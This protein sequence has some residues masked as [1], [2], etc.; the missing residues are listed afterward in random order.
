M[1]M[2]RARIGVLVGLLALSASRWP[3]AA[4]S[5]VDLSH[6]RLDMLYGQAEFL[7]ETSRDWRPL[8]TKVRAL[9]DIPFGIP[10]RTVPEGLDEPERA[11]TN[12]PA[13][14][15]IQPVVKSKPD[16]RVHW[17]P[18]MMESLYYTGIMHGFRTLTEPGTRDALNGP[19]LQ[20]YT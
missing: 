3:A 20:N 15:A 18:A 10:M 2:R 19:W 7:D 5:S 11:V 17:M 8:R 4:Q 9:R 13:F 12:L 1:S 16:S 6:G 14:T